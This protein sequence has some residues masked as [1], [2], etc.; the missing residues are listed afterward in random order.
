MLSRSAVHWEK[1][2][3]FKKAFNGGIYTRAPRERVVTALIIIRVLDIQ[4]GLHGSQTILR[5]LTEYNKI[6]SKE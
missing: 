3:C 1:Y 4:G 5:W 2:S 6:K